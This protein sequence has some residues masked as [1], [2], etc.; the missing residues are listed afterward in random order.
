MGDA[1]NVSLDEDEPYLG[2]VLPG[3][4]G[5]GHF[6][7]RVYMRSPSKRGQMATVR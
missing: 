7:H 5:E 4:E 1:L 6:D 3:G 2:G